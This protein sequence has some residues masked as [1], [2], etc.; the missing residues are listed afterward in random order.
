MQ[1]T[2]FIPHTLSNGR[3]TM[4]SHQCAQRNEVIRA[5]S[6]SIALSGE[7]FLPMSW[8][9]EGVGDLKWVYGDAKMRPL[10][11]RYRKHERCANFKCLPLDHSTNSD[12]IIVWWTRH[13]AQLFSKRVVTSFKLVVKGFFSHCD[14]SF[15]P[16]ARLM[17]NHRTAK[18]ISFLW[19]CWKRSLIAR[20][21][22]ISWHKS[23]L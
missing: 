23:L 21:S 3:S 7:W 13:F 22:I 18:H 1:F 4:Q 2:S 17:L 11:G 8:P 10:L 9:G 16:P 12:N 6:I 14:S 5:L 19:T 20:Y 15:A